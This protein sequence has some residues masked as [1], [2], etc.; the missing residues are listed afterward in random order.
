MAQNITTAQ[1]AEHFG[2]KESIGHPLGQ[3]RLQ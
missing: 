2:M 3:T 1:L